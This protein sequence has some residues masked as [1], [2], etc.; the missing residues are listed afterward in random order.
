MC[1]SVDES[2]DV[3]KFTRNGNFI[4]NWD[5]HDTSGHTGFALTIDSSDNVYVSFLS[6]N[7]VNIN[8]QKFDSDGN[9]ISQFGSR[10]LL[11][12]DDRA[13]CVDPDGTGPLELGDGQFIFPTGIAFDSTSNIYVTDEVLSRVQK[14]DSNGNF[15]TKWGTQG[16]GDGQFDHPIGIAIDSSDKVYVTDILNDR[17]QKFDSRGNFVTKWGNHGNADGQFDG[18]LGITFDSSQYLYISDSHNDHIQ[19]FLRPDF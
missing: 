19:K 14:F 17:I 6:D 15:V 18:P 2:G 16:S 8:I 5:S 9:F 13:G 12:R 7:D 10:C 3:Q 1:T 4:T 11:F